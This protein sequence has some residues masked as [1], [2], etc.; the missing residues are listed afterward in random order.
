[1]LEAARWAPTHKRTEPWNF[2][3]LSGKSKTQFE[4]LTLKCCEELL[5]ADEAYKVMTKLK[6]KQ[7]RD[8]PKVR[9]SDRA[10][11]SIMWHI[12]EAVCCG[13]AVEL[14]PAASHGRLH[15]QGLALTMVNP[16]ERQAAEYAHHDEKLGNI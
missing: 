12:L 16:S 8:W 3:V 2:V 7:Q 9:Q 15:M 11:S 5:Q 1:M 4:E 6:R 13:F 10:S 14:H